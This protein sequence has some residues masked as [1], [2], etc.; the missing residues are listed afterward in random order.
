MNVMQAKLS[1]MFKRAILVSL[2]LIT[3]LQIVSSQEGPIIDNTKPD[4]ARIKFQFH[5]SGDV[6]SVRLIS[7]LI[8]YFDNG[9]KLNY[10]N[11]GWL[12]NVGNNDWALTLTVDNRLR[13]PYR[14]ELTVATQGKD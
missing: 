1:R 5:S 2:I 11:T 3:V 8:P 7:E 12:K 13:I 9:T 4:S 14:Y 6:K 10:D